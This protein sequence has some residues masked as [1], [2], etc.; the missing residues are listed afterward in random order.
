V[1]GRRRPAQPVVPETSAEH[2]DRALELLDEIYEKD[3]GSR[4]AWGGTEIRSV[5]LL[6]QA[7][8]IALAN[9]HV[10]LSEVVQ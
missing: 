3:Q 9:L 1:I 4:N 5:L 2:L 8:R 7:N 10:A 6:E